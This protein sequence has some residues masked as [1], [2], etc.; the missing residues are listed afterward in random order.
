MM[1]DWLFG[2]KRSQDRVD[3]ILD[4]LNHPLF[5]EAVVTTRPQVA[6]MVITN[7]TVTDYDADGLVAFDTE[8][9][10]TSLLRQ[11]YKDGTKLTVAIFAPQPPPA[12]NGEAG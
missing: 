11:W 1:F 5:K 12:A 4:G 7:V 2:N 6:D 9:I 3:R 8:F 10:D